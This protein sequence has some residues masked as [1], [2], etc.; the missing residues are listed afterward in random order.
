MG[1]FDF[2]TGK[3]PAVRFS[4]V[5]RSETGL[6]RPNNEDHAFADDRKGLYAVA[7]GMG[8]GDEGEV[9]SDIVCRRLA[10]LALDGTMSLG[11]RVA[12][13]RGAVEAANAEIFAYATARGFRQMGS[14]VAVLVTDPG[15]AAKA[16][17]CHVGDSRVYR[18]RGGMAKLLTRDHSV[19]REL[20][21]MAGD[22]ARQLRDRSNPLAHVL[23]QA[24]GAKA[25]VRV[26]VLEVDVRPRDRFVIC[27]DGVHDVITDARLAVYAAG[28]PL[29]SAQQRLAAAVVEKG[30][31]DNFT[32]VLVA[33]GEEY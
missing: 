21:D 24:I 22:Q 12:A 13:V 4:S 3:R 10:A 6:V 11:K 5:M 7:D 17:V 14:T 15:D 16:A 26:D 20:S 23:T 19:G 27:S 33:C 29:E 9:A 8:G 32:F 30:A 18:I 25:D 2:F 31:P 28:G 1:M